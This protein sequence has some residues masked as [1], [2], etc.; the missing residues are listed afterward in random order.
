M[1]EYSKE[2]KHKYCNWG[3]D[4]SY[5]ITIDIDFVPD[6]MILDTINLLKENGCKA[7]F[8]I[9]H[10]S[11]AIELLKKEKS[12][13]IG[14]H[15]NLD[16]N[17]TQ[18]GSGSKEKIQYIRNLYSGIVSNKFHILGYS[19]KDFYLLKDCGIKFDCSMCY[20]ET[21]YLLPA[22]H[23]DVDL[24]ITPYWW[25]D[26]LTLAMKK[27][28][29]LDKTAIK[30]PGIKIFTF[31]PLDIYL[32]TYSFEIRNKIKLL[33][34][35]V[36]NITKEELIGKKNIQYFG[37]RDYFIEL[38]NLSKLPDVKFITCRDLNNAFR[39]II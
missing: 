19:Y 1:I 12:F 26:G 28:I 5:I 23:S 29:G 10:D 36:N 30:T 3:E 35:S 18:K 25:E 2:F 32:N 24:V 17:S 11:K 39:S 7:T 31:H 22:Y 33:K 6:F 4:K 20:Y 27:N 8:F 9:T 13:E 38:L 15:P 37:I 21:P 34:S 16:K 14:I